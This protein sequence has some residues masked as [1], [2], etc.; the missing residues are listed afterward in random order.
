MQLFLDL[1]GVL[2]DFD[3]HY[4]RLFGHRLDRT[5]V[6]PP[7]LWENIS[8]EQTFYRDLPPLPDAMELWEG[9]KH[10]DPVILTGLPKASRGVP[11]A[12]KHKRE[13][14][15]EHFGATVSVVCCLSKDKRCHGKPGDVLI[16][17]WAMYRHL[18]IAMG[19][20]FIL[21]TSAKNSLYAL[22]TLCS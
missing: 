18:W 1:D 13:W 3:G 16:D 10:L 20:I 19:G 11:L 22:R 17:D 9:V 5:V 6:D 4:E 21:H 2:A 15:A 7:N 14:V 8:T 12:E